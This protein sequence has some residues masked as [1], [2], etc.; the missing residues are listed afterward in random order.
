MPAGAEL[1][2]WH[3]GPSKDCDGARGS[4]DGSCGRKFRGCRPGRCPWKA[5]PS[6]LRRYS[7]KSAFCNGF[8]PPSA[9]KSVLI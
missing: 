9:E 4:E 7:T 8:V 6:A 2:Q 3:F 5:A 1:P